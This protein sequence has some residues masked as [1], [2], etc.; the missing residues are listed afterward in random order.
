M[1]HRV[2]YWMAGIETFK[3]PTAISQAQTPRRQTTSP[4]RHLSVCGFDS[5]FITPPTPL[6][7]LWMCP[8]TSN[9]VWESKARRQTRPVY[10]PLWKK[11]N[12]VTHSRKRVASCLASVN[13]QV[14]FFFFTLT[15]RGQCR[16][17]VCSK[18]LPWQQVLLA[19]AS[20][21]ADGPDSCNYIPQH[22]LCAVCHGDQQGTY[23]HALV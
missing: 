2:F 17:H 23:F 4:W 5:I 21:T 15:R 18:R 13:V 3:K 6:H 19:L 8:A 9:R 11:K 10:Y 22:W 16:C 1:V 7:H 14:M 20:I 12:T